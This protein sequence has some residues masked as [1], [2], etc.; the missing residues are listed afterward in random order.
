MPKRKGKH[1]TYEDRCTIED[2]LKRHTSFREIA[3]CIDVSPTTI[4]NEIKR[5]RTKRPPR[6]SLFD[7]ARRCVHFGSCTE[8]NV[9]GSCTT[10]QKFCRDCRAEGCYLACKKFEMKK[11]SKL[12]RSPFVCNYCL[13]SSICE[14]GKAFYYARE[15]QKKHDERAS[16]AHA[17]ITCRPSEL[18]SMVD[19]VR[20]LLEQGHSLEAIW[21][22]HA[23]ELP[24]SVRTFYTYMDK[25]VMGLANI[26]LP[27][28]I[29][30]KQRRSR[31]GAPRMELTGRRYSDWRSLTDQERILTVQMDTI[32]GVRSDRKA[33]L[34]LH[35]PRLMFQI[36]L[37]LPSKTQASVVS[38]FDALELYCEG[39]FSKVFA[40]IL[41]DRGSEFLNYLALEASIDNSSSRCRIF[42]CDPM[43]PAQKGAAEKNHVEY[44]KII[45]KGTSID[46]FTQ[47]DMALIT[48][49]VNSYPR[50]AQRQAP[51][52]LAR[53]ALPQSLLDNLGIEE[54]PSDEVIMTPKLIKQL[55][56]QL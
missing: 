32:E 22:A 31:K 10:P 1:L 23:G 21:A 43:K 42:Y 13:S 55:P 48:S 28:K 37:L 12:D 6:P 38:A 14:R 27:K 26:E 16:S 40:V 17:G 3:R 20:R 18:R 44:R 4:S 8:M 34:S 56:S 15:A 50:A 35:F 29:R 47:A 30:Y 52:K 49:H 39:E 46:S 5:N 53:V 7:G 9:C 19:T 24:V 41:T 51:I 36:Y 25:G 45:P 11:C 33:V 2:M 54:I